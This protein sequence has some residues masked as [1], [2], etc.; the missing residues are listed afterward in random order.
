MQTFI[1][2]DYYAATAMQLDRARLNKQITETKQLISAITGTKTGYANHPAALMWKDYLPALHTY[3]CAMLQEW[4]NRGGQGHTTGFIMYKRWQTPWW[5]DNLD[6]QLT[7]RSRLNHKGIVDSLRSAFGRGHWL[8]FRQLYCPSLPKTW[9]EFKP[10]DR[11][12]LA[13]LLEEL[14]MPRCREPYYNYDISPDHSYIWPC[15][16]P[17]RFKTLAGKEWREWTP[18]DP[19]PFNW[20]EQ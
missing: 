20:S 3:G 10:A 17:G 7:H 13:G 14:Q 1:T 9:N 18:G 5:S 2:H 6:V 4:R 12:H 15:R 16:E 11:N 19:L 8:A